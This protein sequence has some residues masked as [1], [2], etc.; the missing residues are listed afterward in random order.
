MRNLF[1]LKNLLLTA[2]SLYFAGNSFASTVNPEVANIG[3]WYEDQDIRGVLQSRLGN[4]SYIAPAAHNA[5]DLIRDVA[6]AAIGEALAGRPALIP[7]NLGNNHWTA[8]A[9]R[10]RPDGTLVVFYNDSFGGSAGGDGS[11]S[12]KYLAAIKALLSDAQIIDLQVRQQSDGSSCGAFTAENLIALANLADSQLTAEGARTELEKITDA[13][14]IR[15]LHLNAL[16]SLYQKIVRIEER[17]S[18][19]K[20]HE[21]VEMSGSVATSNLRSL[22]KV[23]NDR[24]GHLY[25]LSEV[26]GVNSGDESSLYG[27]WLSRA[28]SFGKDQAGN[29]HNVG[30]TTFG[31]DGK[32][33]DETTLGIAVSKGQGRLKNRLTGNGTNTEGLIG[34]LYGSF[35][36]DDQLLFS[37]DLR[38]GR[39]AAKSFYKAITGNINILKL[40]GSISG[41]SGEVAYHAVLEGGSIF[42]I[43]ALGVSWDETDFAKSKSANLAIDKSSISRFLIN[44]SL[45]VAGIWNLGAFDLMT[46]VFGKILW[47]GMVKAKEVVIRNNFGVVTSKVRPKVERL[48]KELGASFTVAGRVL[49]LSAGLE[50]GQCGRYTDHTGFVK[51]RV[52]V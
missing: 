49:E 36:L 20:L 1:W 14:A 2:S 29:K 13:K 15:Q 39:F 45:K 9:I 25:F 26:S 43:P 24:V 11:E 44:P 52:N 32:I 6:N 46:E 8:L 19:K 35:A 7:V 31:L 17:E 33:D 27:F 18:S 10:R 42:L 3:Y 16:G 41:A 5:D 37:G 47:P 34:S 38:L 30:V 23:T 22:G 51:L 40:K 28:D 4:S 21:S 48:R 50:R 12:G